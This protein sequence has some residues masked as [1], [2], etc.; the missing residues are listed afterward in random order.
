MPDEQ[1]AE[2]SEAEQIRAETT[3]DTSQLRAAVT[4]FAIL[5]AAEWGDLTQ[6]LTA[7]LAARSGSPVSVALGSWLALS[8]VA[9]IGV[10]VGSWLTGHVPL[11]RMR[12]IAGAVLAVLAVL[13]SIQLVRVLTG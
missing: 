9:G 2:E 3:A 13:T 12:L 11:W 4:T 1:A 10:L 6:L 5:F 7:G 8:G